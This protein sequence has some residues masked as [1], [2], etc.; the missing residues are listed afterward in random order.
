MAIVEASSI[1]PAEIAEA[2]EH[3]LSLSFLNGSTP[4]A[5]GLKIEANPKETTAENIAGFLF[6]DFKIFCVPW[7]FP[8]QFATLSATLS[9]FIKN[10]RNVSS[11][12]KNLIPEI[13]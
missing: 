12:L 2:C 6:T 10:P 11:T 7:L 4:I 5:A 13:L 9:T 1:K 8:I 3:F